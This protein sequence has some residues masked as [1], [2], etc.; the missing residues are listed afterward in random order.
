MDSCED[1][2]FQITVTWN[3]NPL[4]DALPGDVGGVKRSAI[5]NF[6]RRLRSPV[7]S[8][9]KPGFAIP[10]PIND[11][12]SILFSFNDHQPICGGSFEISP[13]NTSYSSSQDVIR[14]MEDRLEHRH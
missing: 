1:V 8:A 2:L 12:Q 10:F 9:C 7:Q 5:F 4:Q 6:V 13:M 14:A 3:K 11:H